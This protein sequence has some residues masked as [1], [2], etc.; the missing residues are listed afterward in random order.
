MTP[1]SDEAVGLVAAAATGVPS[2]EKK[3]PVVP[4][5][6]AAHAIGGFGGCIQAASF[7]CRTHVFQSVCKCQCVALLDRRR[8]LSPRRATGL[9]ICVFDPAL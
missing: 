2:E 8:N 9:W 1:A 3:N 5:S 7:C 4:E 6:K